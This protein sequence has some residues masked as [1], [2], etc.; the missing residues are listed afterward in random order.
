MLAKEI[1]AEEMCIKLPSLY[2]EFDSNKENELM[3]KEMTYEFERVYLEKK[4]DNIIPD[5]ILESKGN[6]LFVEIFVTHDVDEIKLEKI[7]KLGISSL[8]VDLSELEYSI[9][10][11]ELREI[12]I[13]DVVKK[14]WIYNRK[15]KEMS[16]R[17]KDKARPFELAS[18]G[19]G[20]FCPQYLHGWKGYHQLDG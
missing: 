13:N 6:K 16:N 20:T 12:L 5:I 4:F 7:K 11:D 15:Q 14:R 3:Y 10:K 9:S 2:L 18:K 1:L 17:F 19:M 8:I